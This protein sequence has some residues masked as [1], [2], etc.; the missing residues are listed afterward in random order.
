MLRDNIND[1]IQFDLQYA[2]ILIFDRDTKKWS[3]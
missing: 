3:W 1:E 2:M